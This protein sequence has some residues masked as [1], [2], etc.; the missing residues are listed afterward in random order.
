MT[1]EFTKVLVPTDFSGPSTAALATAKMVAGKF[2]ASLH[3]IHVLEDPFVS[4]AFAPEVYAPP[5]AGL[6]D[7]LIKGAEAPLTALLTAEEQAAFRS[8][9]LVTFGSP[10]SVISEYAAAEHVDLIVIGTHGRGGVA[11]LLMGSV[12]ERVVRTAPCA[13]LTVHDERGRAARKKVADERSA[14]TRG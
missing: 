3:L 7:S 2:G 11:H 12:A 10:A 14:S 1:R 9:A 5:P 6:R 8:T 4:S 13:V